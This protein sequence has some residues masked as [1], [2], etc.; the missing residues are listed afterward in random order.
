MSMTLKKGKG[1]FKPKFTARKPAAPASTQSSARPSVE[2]QSQTPAPTAQPPEPIVIPDQ[3]GD[4]DLPNE[5]SIDQST[6]QSSTPPTTTQQILQ[7]EAVRITNST[8]NIL[9]RKSLPDGAPDLAQ[10]RARIDE[11]SS[12]DVG[13]FENEGDRARGTAQPQPQPAPAHIQILQTETPVAL[14]PAISQVQVLV[15]STPSISPSDSNLTTTNANTTPTLPTPSHRNDSPPRD[16]PNHTSNASVISAAT[17]TFQAS[18]PAQQADTDPPHLI[19]QSHGTPSTNRQEVRQDNPTSVYPDPELSGIPLSR[20][21][22]TQTHTIVSS[23]ALNPDGTTAG[24]PVPAVTL[25][26]DGTYT[27]AADVPA[28]GFYPDGTPRI[29][30]QQTTKPKKKPTARRRRLVQTRQEGDDVRPTIEM[31][32]NRP[33]R[34]KAGEKGERRSRK[35][36]EA[37]KQKKKKRSDTPDG[38]EDEIIDRTAMTMGDLCKDLKIGEKSS[39]HDELKAKKMEEKQKAKEARRAKKLAEAGI[40]AEGTPVDGAAAAPAPQP[41]QEQEPEPEVE[42]GFNPTMVVINGQI[43]LNY[44][45]LEVARNKG[46]AIAANVVVENEFSKLVTSGSLMKRELPTVWDSADTALFYKGLSM[47]GTDFGMM[48]K[49]FPSRNRRQIKLKYAIEE[50]DNAKKLDRLLNAPKVPID[51]ELFNEHHKDEL[52]DVAEIEDEMREFEENELRVEEERRLA[53]EE[54]DRQKR[55]EIQSRGAAARRM[56]ESMDDEGSGKEN[57]QDRRKRSVSSKKKGNGKG[58]AKATRN[59][60]DRPAEE[61]EDYY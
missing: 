60:R 39:R 50:R 38:A 33:R 2:R 44:R 22:N 4:T 14:P 31:Q 18:Q 27:T 8:E 28:T 41:E 58:K 16:I 35:K 13:M 3:H 25:N 7:N 32:I 52:V 59:T 29:I 5:T 19:P 45:S 23:A 17:P 51:L 57:E 54:A 24:V 61:V 37:E 9:K 55:A 20:A 26:P 42:Q 15:A 47:F 48:A 40:E 6:P 11:E 10:K 43:N 53:R 34:R 46:T 30:V 36:K 49:L 56:L 1:A 12:S 21:S